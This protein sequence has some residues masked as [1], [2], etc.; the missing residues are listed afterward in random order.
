MVHHWIF[1]SLPYTDYNTG[2]INEFIGK[3]K[4][5]GKWAIG[6]R[7]VYRRQIGA[8]DRVLFY[9]AGE[10]KGFVGLGEIASG[11]QTDKEDIFDFVL[12]KDID[13][14]DRPVSID[15]LLACLPFIKDKRHWGLYFRGGVNRI[16]KEDYELVL[17]KVKRKRGV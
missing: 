9:Q 3:I 11:L 13:L 14:W 10:V 5:S 6:R 7:T 1:V 8:G 17:S 15:G 2:T 12:V 16:G 4:Q